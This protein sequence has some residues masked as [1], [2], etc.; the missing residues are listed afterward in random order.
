MSAVPPH[1][2][3]KGKG[4][5]G[6]ER[7][8]NSPYSELEVRS[9]EVRR[10]PQTGR[11]PESGRWSISQTLACRPGSTQPG[12]TAKDAGSHPTADRGESDKQ[13]GRRPLPGPRSG[14]ASSRPNPC[15][16][17]ELLTIFSSKGCQLT[18]RTQALWLVSFFTM[19]PL[20]RSYTVQGKPDRAAVGPQCP[21]WHH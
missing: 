8:E 10:R 9:T 13:S 16:L 17:T 2:P 1:S 18:S 12:G 3:Q 20:R 21:Q 7:V 4:G 6:R 11:A 5:G 19:W 14:H 15:S